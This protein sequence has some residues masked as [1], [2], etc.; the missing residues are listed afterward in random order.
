MDEK[1]K[2]FLPAQASDFIVMIGGRERPWLS[3]ALGMLLVPLFWW[4]ARRRMKR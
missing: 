3:R 2:A 1:H 4:R